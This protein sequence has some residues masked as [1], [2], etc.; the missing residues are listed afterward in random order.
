MNA[1]PTINKALKRLFG[2]KALAATVST[3]LLIHAAVAWATTNCLSEPVYT[4]APCDPDVQPLCSQIVWD[5]P[6]GCYELYGGGTTVYWCC[7]AGK[8]CGVLDGV[9]TP[10][11]NNKCWGWCT[12][13]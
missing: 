1:K 13:P 9:D 11:G 7:P 6:A 5:S 4:T 12:C 3:G 10:P 2:P 8:G